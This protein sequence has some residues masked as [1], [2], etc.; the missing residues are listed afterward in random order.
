MPIPH[1]P[2]IAAVPPPVRDAVRPDRRWQ[3]ADELRPPPEQLVEIQLRNMATRSLVGCWD[4]VD[5]W[6]VWP[7]GDPGAEVQSAGPNELLW[8]VL[9]G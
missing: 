7:P 1:N 2:H 8:R 4:V 6:Q 3:R 9:H 5:G